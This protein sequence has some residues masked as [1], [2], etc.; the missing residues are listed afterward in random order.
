MLYQ[1][2]QSANGFTNVLTGRTKEAVV[3]T[4]SKGEYGFLPGESKPYMPIGGIEALK[5]VLEILEFRP[6]KFIHKYQITFDDGNDEYMSIIDEG[7]NIL[8]VLFRL[9]NKTWEVNHI[10]KIEKL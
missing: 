1:K 9:M 4:N 8:Q 6:Y 7:E 3:A 10:T 2:I 5:S